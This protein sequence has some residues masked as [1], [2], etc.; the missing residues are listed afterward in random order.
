MLYYGCDYYPEHWPKSR[1]EED[2]RGQVS[3]QPPG[4]LA[5]LVGA[6]VEE[7]DSLPPDQANRVRF[8]EGP[9]G[10]APV[11]LWFEVLVPGAARPLAVYEAEYYAGRPAVTVRELGQGRAIYVGV[12]AAA[13]FYGLLFDWLLPQVDVMPVLET[14]EGIE[15]VERIGT[16]GRIVFLLNHNQAAATVTLPEGTIDALTN[17]PLGRHLELG[18]REV[19]MA[20]RAIDR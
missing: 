18:P 4:Y 19:Q 6:T 20:V 11:S 8:V 13:D 9:T 10:S 2:A 7:F 12:L 15:A 16:A 1:W 5:E 17:E 3:G 14:P